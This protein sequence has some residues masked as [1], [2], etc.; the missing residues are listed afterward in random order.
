MKKRKKF[1]LK[2]VVLILIV[3]LCIIA[4]VML[5]INNQKPVGQND[6]T[7]LYF[8]Y[9]S[10]MNTSQMRERC[11]TNVEGIGPA[12]LSDYEFGFDSR[13]YANI[14]SKLG[15]FVWGFVWRID[16]KCISSLDIYEG[17]PNTYGRKDVVVMGES[18]KMNAFVYIQSENEFGGIP[19]I[20]YL[21]NKIISGAVENK[22]PSEWVD[23]LKQYN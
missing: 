13:G 17:Y 16:E 2:Y 1:K 8:A 20:E 22:L 23:K 19:Q 3:V 7:Q 14:R 21:N 6:K 5:A 10:N 9:G 11:P 12:K 18:Q 15:E 4:I